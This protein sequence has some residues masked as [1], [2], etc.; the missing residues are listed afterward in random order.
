MGE[1]IV[2]ENSPVAS[3]FTIEILIATMMPQSFFTK[4]TLL[5]SRETS[6]GEDFIQMVL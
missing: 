3:F 6:C 2:S 1:K 5:K 4:P